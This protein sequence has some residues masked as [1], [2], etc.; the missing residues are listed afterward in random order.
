M[1]M[2]GLFTMAVH[3]QSVVGAD[4]RRIVSKLS[5]F[6]D[7]WLSLVNL[8]HYLHTIYT[9]PTHYLHTIYTLTGYEEHIVGGGLVVVIG[10]H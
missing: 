4:F 6:L 1:R 7:S 8:T 9:L 2:L 5:D 3:W 10:E